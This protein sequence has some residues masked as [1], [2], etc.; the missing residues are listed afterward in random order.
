MD[1]G[2]E[3]L[4]VSAERREVEFVLHTMITTCLRMIAMA[5]N[6]IW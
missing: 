4:E 5:M 2:F 1:P 3:I 6:W